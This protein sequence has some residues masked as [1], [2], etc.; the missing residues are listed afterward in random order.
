M[1]FQLSPSRPCL[2]TTCHCITRTGTQRG[3]SIFCLSR[4]GSSKGSALATD[5]AAEAAR[6]QGTSSAAAENGELS[7]DMAARPVRRLWIQTNAGPSYLSTRG[8]RLYAAL[9]CCR[10]G[11]GFP[12]LLESIVYREHDSLPWWSFLT[13]PVRNGQSTGTHQRH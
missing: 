11:T 1:A 6:A 4:R 7:V 12:P 2:S 13:Q 10:N 8:H 3:G 5:V 9:R